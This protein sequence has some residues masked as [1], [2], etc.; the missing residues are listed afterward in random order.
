MLL[1]TFS[2]AMPV[3]AEGNLFTNGS[4]SDEL[5]VQEEM[6]SKIV[7]EATEFREEYAKYF[8][9][10]DGSYVVATYSEPVHYKENKQWKEI[11][12]TL[13]LNADVKS[14]SGKAMFTPKAGLIDV[15]I[16]QNFENGQKVSTTNKG[17]TISFGANHDKIIYQNKPTAVV[18][19]TS[20]LSSSKMT[21]NAVVAKKSTAT[22]SNESEITAFN[23]DAMTVENQTGAVVYEDVFGKADLEY[24]VT[25]NSIKENIVVNE[26]QNKYIYSFD[27][28]FGEL[29]PVV[30]EDNSIRLVEPED[31][32]E[33]VFYIESPYIYDANGIKSEDIDMSLIEKDGMY[34]M[35]LQA[36]AEWINSAERAFPVIIDPTV[37]LSFDDVFVMDGIPNKNT[38]KIN[39][40][41][42]VGRILRILQERISNLL[43]P[44]IYPQE[45]ISTV[46]I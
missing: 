21:D 41:L 31:T 34:V 10:E 44:I 14:D 7:R 18:K 32:E 20:D 37:Y 22:I 13:K 35:T 25:T 17:Y 8:I 46:H 16:P 11:D 40:E 29:V 1:T 9:C 39:D 6:T 36:N 5:T 3:F 33:T 43:F 38:T 2:V 30:N 19:D 15:K 42:R 24:V 45:A 26:K 27:M 4:I 12:N 23:N 28:D